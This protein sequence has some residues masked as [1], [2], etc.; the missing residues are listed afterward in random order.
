MRTTSLVRAAAAT[1]GALLLAGCSS[2]GPADVASGDY[3]AFAAS[4]AVGATPEATLSVSDSAFTFTPT[5]GARASATS[6]PGTAEFVLCPP[7]T[8]GTP[9]LLGPSLTI[10]TV[11]LQQ[12]AVFGDCGQTTPKR[13]TVVDLASAS[14]DVG[15]FPF[16]R[17]I[18]FCDTADPD[19]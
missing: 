14:T 16:T 5:D 9:T 13:I 4:D 3:R 1:A 10:G 12:P 6:S 11:T 7:D 17:W 8:T 19:C 2:S 18:E 15:P